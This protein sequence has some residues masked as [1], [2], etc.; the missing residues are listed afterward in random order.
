MVFCL[1]L[2]ETTTCLKISF[3]SSHTHSSENGGLIKYLSTRTSQI[4][5][6]ALQ[7]SLHWEHMGPTTA[8]VTGAE[9]KAGVGRTPSVTLG[10]RMWAEHPFPI[11]EDTTL[12]IDPHFTGGRRQ[13]EDL[14]SFQL[15]PEHITLCQ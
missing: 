8:P 7:Q 10:A 9:G 4:T 12:N 6:P 2:A 14:G 13:R 11:S 3:P 1:G 15:P 5:Q